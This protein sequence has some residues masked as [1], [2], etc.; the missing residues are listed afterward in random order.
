MDNA[1]Y[2]LHAHAVGFWPFIGKKY[3]SKNL[4]SH[5]STNG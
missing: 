1:S 4:N 3:F 5:F 2:V